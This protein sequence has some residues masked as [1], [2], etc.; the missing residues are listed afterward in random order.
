MVKVLGA[1]CDGMW[2]TDVF[3]IEEIEREQAGC[4]GGATNAT[5]ATDAGSRRAYRC[6]AP[7]RAGSGG[8]S[9]DRRDGRS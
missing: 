5:S 7:S 6:G 9:R 4:R 8:R 1:V 2:G 3:R